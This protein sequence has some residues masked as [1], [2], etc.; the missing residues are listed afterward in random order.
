M[1]LK[2]RTLSRTSDTTETRNPCVIKV[3][4]CLIYLISSDIL[5]RIFVSTRKLVW[6][7]W[8]LGFFV[9]YRGQVTAE[10]MFLM[11]A[12]IAYRYSHLSKGNDAQHWMK[13]CLKWVIGTVHIRYICLS[14]LVILEVE[15]ITRKCTFGHITKK[16]AL[17]RHTISS[18]PFLQSKQCLNPK[19]FLK[20][21]KTY[22]NILPV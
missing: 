3:I 21:I 6:Y 17:S 1:I 22:W 16:G 14:P 19:M 18:A 8:L 11:A 4:Y 9:W 12:A 20:Q 2:S 15:D 5:T 13:A 10:S 7:P